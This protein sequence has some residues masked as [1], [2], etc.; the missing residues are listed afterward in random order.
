MSRSLRT[1]S[2]SSTSVA[3]VGGGA[4]RVPVIVF[5]ALKK[6]DNSATKQM[7]ICVN[8]ILFYTSGVTAQ[9]DAL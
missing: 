3:G 1:F 8:I 2:A 5:A 9:F 4:V 7:Q 6:A